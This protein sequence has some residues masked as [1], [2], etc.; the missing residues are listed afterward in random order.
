MET[1]EHR[2]SLVWKRYRD[3]LVKSDYNCSLSE[4]C[5]LSNTHY[6]SM[7]V[8]LSRQGYSVSKLREEIR[9]ECESRSVCPPGLVPLVAREVPVREFSVKGVTVTFHSGTVLTVREGTP[10][11]IVRLIREYERKEGE[12]CSL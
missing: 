7:S 8:W 6:S 9:G 3:Y 2:F 4:F 10:E 1:A 12:P 11:G 5:K